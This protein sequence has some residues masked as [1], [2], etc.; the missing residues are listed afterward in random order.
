MSQLWENNSI[1]DEGLA[2]VFRVFFIGVFRGLSA[3]AF[4]DDLTAT[5]Q[6]VLKEEFGK[7]ISDPHWIPDDRFKWW[8]PQEEGE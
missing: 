4:V 2:N 6:D 1:E 8:L 7:D 3:T 5:I